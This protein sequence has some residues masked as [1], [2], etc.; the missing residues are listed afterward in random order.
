MA[1][2]VLSL[3]AYVMTRNGMLEEAEVL[4]QKLLALHKSLF[5]PKQFLE[6]FYDA[7]RT[8]KKRFATSDWHRLS[9]V[10]RQ[11]SWST[12]QYAH[13]CKSEN[14]ATRL[15]KAKHL[16]HRAILGFEE[17]CGLQDENT[18]NAIHRLGDALERQQLYEDALQ[19]HREA[20][21]VYDDMVGKNHQFKSRL[22]ANIRR[23][24]SFLE[25]R[26][27]FQKGTAAD[28]MVIQKKRLDACG[29][30][31]PQTPTRGRASI[32]RIWSTIWIG[33]TDTG[34]CAPHRTS[35]DLYQTS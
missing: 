2:I 15:S 27:P 18:L 26:D 3:L 17:T 14:F 34:C 8:T 30:P 1:I 5:G 32:D 7:M 24:D 6:S 19:Q 31:H 13:S 10:G 35:F 9:H 25:A 29:F 11:T 21:R 33:A 23:L 4:S 22:A 16:P 12:G 20:Y 28:S